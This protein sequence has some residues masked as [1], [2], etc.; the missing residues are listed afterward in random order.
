MV[1]DDHEMTQPRLLIVDDHED[2]RSSARTLLE[3]EG[4]DVVGVAADGPSALAAVEALRPDIVL[5]DV[6]L[7]GMDGF[8]VVRQLQARKQRPRVVLISSRDRS[9]YAVELREAAVVGF[10]GKSELSGAAL[11]ALVA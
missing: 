7:P 1:C 3:L 8:D 11:H 6:Q 4:F 10:L 2:F 9:A 5:L